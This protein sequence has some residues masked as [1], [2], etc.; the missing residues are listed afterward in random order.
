MMFTKTQFKNMYEDVEICIANIKMNP[1]QEYFDDLKFALNKLFQSQ[2][3]SVVYTENIDKLF[4]G[5]YIMPR[6]DPNETIQAI[7][8][9]KKLIVKAYDI[10][11]D[12]KLFSPSIGLTNREIT[13]LIIHDIGAMVLD[14][15]PAQ[16]VIKAIDRYLVDNHQVLKLSDSIH[17]RQILNLGFRDAIRKCTSIFQLGSYNV[18]KDI[19]ADFIDW[20]NYKESVLSGLNKIESTG[21][22]IN[23]NL[24]NKFIVLSWLMRV[25]NDVVGYRLSVIRL[26]ERMKELSPSKIER[27]ELDTL[28]KR[29]QLIDDDMLL[30]SNKSEMDFE[31]KELLESI[32]LL[33]FPI[34]DDVY[35]CLKRSK[36]DLVGIVLQQ[37]NIDPN[38]P[39]AIPDLIHNINNS[40]SHIKDYVE[41]HETNKDAF[42]QFDAIYRDMAK[43]RSQLNDGKMYVVNY[44]LKNKFTKQEDQ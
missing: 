29:I 36:N 43:R 33:Q 4:F 21:N 34:D 7:T 39:D 5:L 44:G 11:I 35:D 24:D 32:R 31:G 9:T 37:D 27:K 17:Y 40:M 16:E 8:S 13:A 18:E 12:S 23:K 22:N 25:Y 6:I 41:N 19:F 2:C 42:K 1:I 28:N 26:C 38:E 20:T 15:S 14:S 3:S 10:E 30:E